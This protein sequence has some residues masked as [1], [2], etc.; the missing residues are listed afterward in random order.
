[1]SCDA[2]S[3]RG[4]QPEHQRVAT[5]VLEASQYRKYRYQWG[6][7]KGVR[8]NTEARLVDPLLR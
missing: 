3:A 2:R 7:Q 4:A 6:S 5:A 1:M 8:R